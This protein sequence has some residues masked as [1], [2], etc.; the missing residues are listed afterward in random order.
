MK[1]YHKFPQLFTP[2]CALNDQLCYDRLSNT[3]P[4][5]HTDTP[6][7]SCQQLVLGIEDIPPHTPSRRPPSRLR[8][9]HEGVPIILTAFYPLVRL[10]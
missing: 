3:I 9:E 10:E 4:H 5:I 2:W 7:K 6:A 8:P 1:K